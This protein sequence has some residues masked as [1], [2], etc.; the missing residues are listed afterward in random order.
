MTSAALA[1]LLITDF[2]GSMLQS[3]D[4]QIKLD[5]LRNQIQTLTESL[6]SDK[7]TKMFVFGSQHHESCKQI[8]T[9][10]LKISELNS[11][12]ENLSPGSY[13]KTPLAK[14]LDLA[15]DEAK[16]TRT[17]DVLVL[18]DGA[19]TCQGDPCETLLAQDKKLS[20]RSKVRLMIVGYD[21][22]SD[23]KK[24]QCLETLSSKLHNIELIYKNSQNLMDSQQ[25]LKKFA[26]SVTQNQLALSS[27]GKITI[28]GAPDFVQFLATST[29][30]PDIQR[31]WHGDFPIL[32][33]SGSYKLRNLS[34]NSKEVPIQIRPRENHQ[35]RFSE[36]L[37]WTKTE[38]QGIPTGFEVIARPSPA[39]IEGFAINSERKLNAQ[40][41]ENLE[42]G[43][44]VL[45]TTH[46]WWLQ[47]VRFP[48]VIPLEERK[49]Q[50]TESLF[51]KNYNWVL[52]PNSSNPQILQLF[53][54]DHEVRVLIPPS[55]QGGQ[56]TLTPIP[57]GWFYSTQQ[58]ERSELRENHPKD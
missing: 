31:K 50:S 16:E 54:E 28:R 46:P 55:I 56:Q 43:S 29:T 3:F 9:F 33:P 39:T 13:G 48:L 47:G 17:S 49:I 52:V 12:L 10:Q 45:E 21:L 23:Q 26:E 34:K 24:L 30:S 42:I 6:P 41:I 8:Q 32:L 44:W 11:Q 27:D 35:I 51:Q 4:K 37:L 22:K 18:T 57:Q 2:S 5:L 36:T 1:F 7:K 25:A 53:Q 15:L 38:V 40:M 19:D 14:T 58:E 20:F